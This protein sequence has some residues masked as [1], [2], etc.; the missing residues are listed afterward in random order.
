MTAEELEAFSARLDEI[1]AQKREKREKETAENYA[2]LLAENP[3]PQEIEFIDAPTDAFGNVIY[4]KDGKIKE[5]I[6]GTFSPAGRALFEGEGFWRDVARTATQIPL[7]YAGLLA[8]G[9]EKPIPFRDDGASWADL[10]RALESRQAQADASKRT[11]AERRQVEKNIEEFNKAEGLG[12]IIPGAKVI[13]D[14]LSPGKILGSIPDPL[15]FVSVGA[16][17]LAAKV[18][19]STA[20]KVALGAGVGA[21]TEGAINRAQAALFNFDRADMTQEEKDAEK[22]LATAFGSAFGLFGGGLGA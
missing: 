18:I 9:H 22:L 6:A 5:P 4:G 12:A 1:F 20:G 15:N 8:G 14:S 2:R 11:A 7:N 16:G 10:A 3:P 19:K 17:G 21:I 13:I